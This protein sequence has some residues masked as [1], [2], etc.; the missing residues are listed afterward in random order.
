MQGN[1]IVCDTPAHQKTVAKSFPLMYPRQRSG[2]GQVLPQPAAPVQERSEQQQLGEGLGGQ[3]D[4]GA[5][6]PAAARTSAPAHPGRHPRAADAAAGAG[7]ELRGLPHRGGQRPVCPPVSSTRCLLGACEPIGRA[8][9]VAWA[10]MG[11][12]DTA[13]A[14]VLLRGA[15]AAG[16]A[17]TRRRDRSRNEIEKRGG[18]PLWTLLPSRSRAMRVVPSCTGPRAARRIFGWNFGAQLRVL[19]LICAGAFLCGQVRPSS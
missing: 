3:Q 16:A 15:C 11:S 8:L 19:A 5:V 4:G 1:T 6:A 14:L 7:R 18:R 10:R 13:E 17:Q 9:R 2:R 12:F